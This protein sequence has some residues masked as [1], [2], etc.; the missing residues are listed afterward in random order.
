MQQVLNIAGILL[1]LLIGAVSWVV[2]RIVVAP[3]R[4][5]AETSQR[6]AAGDFDVRIPERGQDVIATLARSF[7]GMADSLQEQI[8]ELATLS[9]CS[10]ASSRTS[11]TSCA[12]R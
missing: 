7:N 8:S 1:I 11:R 4:V 12:P 5:A 3:V 9:R 6:L 2:V 10:S